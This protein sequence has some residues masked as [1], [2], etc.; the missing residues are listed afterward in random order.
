LPK[1]FIATPSSPVDDADQAGLMGQ[2]DW[3]ASA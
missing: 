1:P 2:L 3:A